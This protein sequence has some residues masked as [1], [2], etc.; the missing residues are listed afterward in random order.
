MQ[1]IGEV[2]P[3]IISLPSDR[4]HFKQDFYIKLYFFH[5]KISTDWA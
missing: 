2:P 1:K 5:D 3:Y 4:Y